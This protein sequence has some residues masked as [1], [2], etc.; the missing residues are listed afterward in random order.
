MWGAAG[1]RVRLTGGPVEGVGE[2]VGEGTRTFQ[3]N[4]DRMALT[5][6]PL[7]KPQFLRRRLRRETSSGDMMSKYKR[8]VPTPAEASVH[9]SGIL[10]MPTSNAAVRDKS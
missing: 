1:Y 8:R 7:T 5:L 2:T 9:N 6:A 4:G 10:H 3:E